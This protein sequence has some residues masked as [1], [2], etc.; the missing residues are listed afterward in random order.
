VGNPYVKSRIPVAMAPNLP[1][2][3]P[4]TIHGKNSIPVGVVILWKY[5]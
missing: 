4:I 1:T 5:L 3:S 2:K